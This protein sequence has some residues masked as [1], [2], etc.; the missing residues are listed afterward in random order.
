MRVRI[1]FSKLGKVRFVG[2]RD[3]ARLWER[4]L[5]KGSVPV[6]YSEGF[7]PRPRLSFGLAL[8]LGAESYAEYLDVELASDHDPAELEQRLAGL[9]PPG[10][11][12]HAVRVIDRADASLQED[13]VACSWEFTLPTIDLP[14]GAAMV[15]RMLGAPELPL[16]RAR[17]GEKR[18]DD[19]RPAIESL[20]VRP[21]PDTGETVLEARLATRPRGMRPSE[22]LAVAFPEFDDATDLCGRIVRLHQWIERDGARRELVPL[23]AAVGPHAEQV[24]A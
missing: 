17:K 4:T 19:L 24:C 3:V 23:D 2:H 18:V 14:S 5:R 12:V 11:A 9:L 13:V 8:P 6:A 21:D 16:E 22:L 10:F 20:S 15:E 7:S 1:R